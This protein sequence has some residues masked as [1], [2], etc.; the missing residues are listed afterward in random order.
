LSAA[1][2]IVDRREGLVASD[3]GDPKRS[4]F[5]GIF[6]RRR[7]CLRVDRPERQQADCN[8]RERQRLDCP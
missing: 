7:L 2:I 6:Q 1:A 3:R 4:T 8:G 5:L